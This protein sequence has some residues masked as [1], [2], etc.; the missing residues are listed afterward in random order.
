MLCF[1]TI[2]QQKIKIWLIDGMKNV[3]KMSNWLGFPRRERNWYSAKSDTP[4][5]ASFKVSFGVLVEFESQGHVH[6]AQGRERRAERRE[7]TR[8]WGCIVVIYF[9]F[10]KSGY[11][12]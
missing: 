11:R 9:F 8:K 12:V 5:H 4:P 3:K 6:W 10:I 1:R 7:I 2:W